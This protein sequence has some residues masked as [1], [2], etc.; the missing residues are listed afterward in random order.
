MFSGNLVNCNFTGNTAVRG[1][2][3]N[4]NGFSGTN[5]SNSLFLNN[6][7]NAS[8]YDSFDVTV[9]GTALEIAF[10]GQ[11]NHLN[12]IYSKGNIKFTNVTYWGANGIANTGDSPIELSPSNCEAGQ[13]ISISGIVNGK[14]INTSEVTDGNGKIILENASDYYLVVRHESNSY[15]T[16]AE[17]EIS[18]MNVKVTSQETTDMTVNITA[19]SNIPQDIIRGKL[20]FILPNGTEINA[21]YGTDGIW[22]AVHT[23]DAIGEYNV[24]ASY[25]GLDNV[26][27]SNATVSVKAKTVLTGKSVTATYNI[28]KDLVITLKDANG[29]PLTGVNLKVDLNGAKTYTTDNNGQIKVNVA[30]L[31][32]KTYTAKIAF[33]GNANYLGSSADVK[34]TV[35]KAKPKI[36]AKKKTFKVKKS[37]K[38]TVTLKT[39][40]NKALNKVKVTITIKAKGK[41]IKITKTTKKGKATF[42]LKK[43]TKKGKYAATVKF[44]G[45]KYYNKA[46]KKV[47]I[48]VK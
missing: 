19:K 11:N 29:N 30:K 25:H 38:Y 33:E 8:A 27:V 45:N 5:I 40:K 23:F 16:E 47:K 6:R 2:A 15:Y 32:P 20:V 4:L 18:N 17:K 35:K 14:I 13:N 26:A 43:L 44:N 34:V 48:T 21:T 12:A 9:N 46:T 22:W 24:G 37:K 41:K 3:I 7:A 39:N 36:I 1:S 42:N 10:I 31:V 28:N